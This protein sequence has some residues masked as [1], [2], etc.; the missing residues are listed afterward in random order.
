[1]TT[2][3]PLQAIEIA[4]EQLPTTGILAS[5]FLSNAKAKTHNM[6]KPSARADIAEGVEIP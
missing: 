5:S 6:T 3:P 2:S 1:M 4:M